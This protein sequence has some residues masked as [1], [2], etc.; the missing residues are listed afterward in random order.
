MTG[1]NEIYYYLIAP[2]SQ[3]GG[4]RTV[5]AAVRWI[6]EW[7]GVTVPEEFEAWARGTMPP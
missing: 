3:G 7:D 4:G 5:L 6:S 2:K 1:S